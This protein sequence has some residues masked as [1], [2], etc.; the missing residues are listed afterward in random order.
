MLSILQSNLFFQ[1]EHLCTINGMNGI[2]D[3]G[4]IVRSIVYETMC[5][6]VLINFTWT[7]NSSHNQPG[8]K[9]F[10]QK[11]NIFGVFFEVIHAYDK[12]YTKLS[13]EDDL[14]KKIFKHI[15]TKPKN[16]VASSLSS[17]S[18]SQSDKELLPVTSYTQPLSI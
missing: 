6:S 5:P 13:C 17:I 15:K 18:H 14:K 16:V 11:R 10:Q 9:D 12:K 7:G 3:G 4:K 8:K 1:V 2:K